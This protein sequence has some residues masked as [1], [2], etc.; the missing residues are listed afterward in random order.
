[1]SLRGLTHYLFER[2]AF[3]RWS[4]A[5]DGKRSQG[6]LHMYLLGA[7]EQVKSKGVVVLNSNLEELDRVRNIVSDML[8]LARADQ[9]ARA[10]PPQMVSLAAEVLKVTEYFAPLLEEA[11]PNVRVEGA[12]QARMDSA[13]FRRAASKLPHNALQH[14]ARGCTIVV[15][16]G[17][18]ADAPTLSASNP[19]AAI[20]APDLNHQFGRFYR[21]DA[22]RANPGGNH[23]LSL[24]MVKPVAAIHHG[25]VFARSNDRWNTFGS[26]LR[27]GG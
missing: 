17:T 2:T 22:A 16:V 23:G 1:M 25:G 26:T 24:S 3:N 21:A 5:M 12:V 13:Q 10:L 14:G 4:P 20:E 19:G 7:A 9:G 8:F 11:G 15:R 27:D 6:V 18:E